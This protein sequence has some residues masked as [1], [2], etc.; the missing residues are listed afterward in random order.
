MR[1]LGILYLSC[2]VFRWCGD[3][4]TDATGDCDWIF[5]DWMGVCVCTDCYFFIPAGV[6]AGTNGLFAGRK[7][8]YVSIRRGMPRK[9]QRKR[10]GVFVTSVACAGNFLRM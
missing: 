10:D 8:L 7:R 2:D 9:C 6:C 3:G 5:G 1:V 4:D